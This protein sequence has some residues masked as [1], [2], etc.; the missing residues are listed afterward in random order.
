MQEED[1]E[2]VMKTIDA[3]ESELRALETQL[4]QEE[5]EAA[6]DVLADATIWYAH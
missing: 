3:M 6:Q 5:E 1:L 4:A 2:T